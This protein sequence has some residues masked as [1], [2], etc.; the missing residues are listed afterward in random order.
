M[1]TTAASHDTP[2]NVEPAGPKL[3]VNVAGLV[4]E[5]PPWDVSEGVY[6]PVTLAVPGVVGVKRTLQ[7]DVVKDPV[8]ERVQLARSND[9]L[10]PV[11]ENKTEPA[12]G[13]GFPLVE[14][15]VRSAVHCEG[16]YTV[17]GSGEHVTL[18]VVVR[19]LMVMVKF[20]LP[21]VKLVE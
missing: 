15:S 12:G 6:V 2:V 11:W 19:G 20:A 17:T 3:A 8:G 16:E 14:V 1:T 5:L 7:L 18:M 4:V 9:P 21:L 10:V 13:T